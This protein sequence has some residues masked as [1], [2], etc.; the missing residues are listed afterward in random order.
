MNEFGQKV[1]AIWSRVSTHDQRELSLESQEIAV[2]RTLEDLG[3]SC[4]S[5]YQM[6]VDW[7][8]M[9]LMS[10]T[11]FQELRRLIASGKIQAIGTLDRDRLRQLITNIS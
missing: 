4:L 3:Y 1:A 7:S 10:N 2:R 9:D 8:S 6:K 11:Q 5:P